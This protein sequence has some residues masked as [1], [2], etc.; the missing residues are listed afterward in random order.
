MGRIEGFFILLFFLDFVLKAIISGLA[1][2][3]GA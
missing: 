1:A 2:A 3:I